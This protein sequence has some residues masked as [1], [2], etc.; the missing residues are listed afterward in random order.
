[1]VVKPMLA[2]LSSFLSEFVN[3]TAGA[4]LTQTNWR[5]VDLSSGIVSLQTDDRCRLIIADSAYCAPCDASSKFL[6][7]V[8]SSWSKEIRLQFFRIWTY[9]NPWKNEVVVSS[10]IHRQKLFVTDEWKNELYVYWKKR[11]SYRNSSSG[12]LE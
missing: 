10:K 11:L 1:M 4:N 5:M 2:C 6:I 12:F 7:R 3:G 9:S 8:F